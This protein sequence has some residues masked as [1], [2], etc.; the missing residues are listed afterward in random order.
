MLELEEI[1]DDG[2]E[3]LSLAAF[4]SAGG[5]AQEAD[6]ALEDGIDLLEQAA[7]LVRRSPRDAR[8]PHT[9]D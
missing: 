1:R 3:L 6:H 7:E 2:R 5:R 8:D 9:A 4:L